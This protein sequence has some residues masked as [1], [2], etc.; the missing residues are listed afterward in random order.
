MKGMYFMKKKLI[1][2]ALL[3]LALLSGCSGGNNSSSSGGGNSASENAGVTQ[4]GETDSQSS[5]V[6]NF[7]QNASENVDMDAIEGNFLNVSADS[8]G[9]PSEKFESCDIKLSDAKQFELEG[10]SYVVFAIDFTNKTAEDITFTS[11][12]EA[13]AFQDGMQIAPAA[14]PTLPEGIDTTTT[15]QQVHSGEKIKV[16]SQIYDLAQ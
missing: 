16:V 12:I 1:I 2:T 10:S 3:A 6:N 5:D 14:L 8:Q 7:A 13:L 15:M 4:S 9:S 11:A